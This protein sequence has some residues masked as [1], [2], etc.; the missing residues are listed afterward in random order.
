MC[1]TGLRFGKRAAAG[2]HFLG[3]KVVQNH[4]AWTIL[5]ALRLVGLLRTLVGLLWALI[6][7][8]AGLLHAR[9]RSRLL[10]ACLYGRR[11]RFGRAHRGSRS[12]RYRLFIFRAH[13]APLAGLDDNRFGATATHILANG[14]LAHP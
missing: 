3:R 11:R 2:I 9:S 12:R 13:R 6:V 5:L 14:T 1:V 7:L 4:G 8:A 10:R